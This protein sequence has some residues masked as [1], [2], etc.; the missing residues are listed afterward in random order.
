MSQDGHADV[1]C[2]AALLRDSGGKFLI[3]WLQVA[4]T[5]EVLV[6]LQG[7]LGLVLQIIN[8]WATARL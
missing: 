8:N 2:S 5:G 4:W 1:G 3:E 6:L 7:C